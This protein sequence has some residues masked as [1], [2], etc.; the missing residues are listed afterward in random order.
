MRKPKIVA[1]TG[2]VGKTSTK[3]AIFEVLNVA[4]PGQVRKSEGNLNTKFGVALAVLGFKEPPIP[5]D[6]SASV[7]AWLPVIFK[8][9]FRIWINTRTKYLVLE[10]AADSPGDIEFITSYI[11]PNIAVVTNLGQA[12][13]EIFGT[14]EKIIEEKTLLIKNLC[15]GGW[16]V[17]NNDDPES[18]KLIERLSVG[19]KTVAIEGLADVRASDIVTNILLPHPNTTFN[20]G[21]KDHQTK[22]KLNSFGEVGNVYAA[23]FAIAVADLLKIHRDKAAQGLLEVR[24]EKHR[25]E[26]FPGKNESIIID[27]AYNANPLSMKAALNVLKSTPGRKIAVLGGMLELG[28]ISEVSHREIGQ[29]AL[30]TA[31]EVI[32]VGDLGKLYEG[33]KNFPTKEEAITYLLGRVQ[34]GDIILIK[35]SRGIGLEVI[36]E[37]L[38]Q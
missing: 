20:V 13:L 10:L 17:L 11:R 23:L 27:D 15:A 38:K 26:V 30:T 12:H 8:V 32:S 29:L 5:L 24:N 4:F 28:D 33:A 7:W 14:I 1:V 3:D 19:K 37:A 16:A 36:V 18:K 21:S 2:S 9:P 35:A 31:D 25:M 34:K 22:V 6:G